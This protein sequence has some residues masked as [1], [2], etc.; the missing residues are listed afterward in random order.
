[1]E[2]ESPTAVIVMNSTE[3]DSSVSLEVRRS[4]H[5]AAGIMGTI[6]AGGRWRRP[7]DRGSRYTSPGSAD[8]SVQDAAILS[9]RTARRLWWKYQP[10]SLAS[11]DASIHKTPP[12]PGNLR[13]QT[14]LSHIVC[15]VAVD[16]DG[17]D[18]AHRVSENICKSI[19]LV[20]AVTKR[21]V[22]VSVV[23]VITGP[24]ELSRRRTHR[25]IGS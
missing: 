8:V 17:G 22:A 9:K 12:E 6:S 11:G 1:M 18:Q 4:G 5:E 25:H 14:L 10:P 16:R 21:L 13:H 3:A 24:V 19:R 7:V 15:T 20:I 2:K 23:L